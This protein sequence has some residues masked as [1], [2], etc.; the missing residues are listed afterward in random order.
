MSHSTGHQLHHVHNVTHIIKESID[1][2][3]LI[4]GTAKAAAG[5]ALGA[6]AAA[7]LIGVTAPVSVPLIAAGAAIGTA[8]RF[9]GRWFR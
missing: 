1:D 7:T 6:V 4:T 5:G 3:R 2:D 9:I 8:A